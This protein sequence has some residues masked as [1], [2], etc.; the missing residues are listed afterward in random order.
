MKDTKPNSPATSETPIDKRFA[1]SWFCPLCNFVL[2]KSILSTRDGNVYVDNEPFNEICPNDGQM[3]HPMTLSKAYDNLVAACESQIN[4]AVKAELRLSKLTKAGEE[5]AEA[6][7]RD[8]NA[9]LGQNDAWNK[10]Q[11]ALISSE[12]Y[13]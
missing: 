1:G 2:Y 7:R 3:M 9:T 12:K 10:W 6:I 8:D 5:M 13:Q 11:Q 4:R